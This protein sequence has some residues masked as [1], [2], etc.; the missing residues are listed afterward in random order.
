LKDL[1]E[2]VSSGIPAIGERDFLWSNIHGSHLLDVSLHHSCAEGISVDNL[3]ND[4]STVASKRRSGQTHDLGVGESLKNAFPTSG[5]VVVTLVDRDKVKEIIGESG[6]PSVS[7]AGQ[8]LD[9]GDNDMGV[10][11]VVDIRV[12]TIQDGRVR[13]M[14]HVR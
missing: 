3:T 14:V 11:A 7:P 4:L 12:L 13:A 10:F 5:H 8:L 6:K 2:S 1:I 9:I